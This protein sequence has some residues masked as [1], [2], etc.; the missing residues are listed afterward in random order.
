MIS[1]HRSSP[2]PTQ[3]TD[4]LLSYCVVDEIASLPRISDHSLQAV[5]ASDLCAA[6]VLTNITFQCSYVGEI[7]HPPLLGHFCECIQ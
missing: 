1:Q 2:H 3:E 6:V 4:N 5:G 7:I